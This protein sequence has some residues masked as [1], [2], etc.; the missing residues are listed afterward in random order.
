MDFPVWGIDVAYYQSL[1]QTS[2]RRLAEFQANGLAFVIAKASMRDGVDTACVGHSAN[3]RAVSGLALGHYHWVDPTGGIHPDTRFRQL[4]HLERMVNQNRPD[5]IAPDLEHWW[6]SWESYWQASQGKLPWGQVP[7]FS[8]SYLNEHAWLIQQE[9]ERRFAGLPII[10]YT[11]LWFVRQ[12][13]P[14]MLD[15][16]SQRPSW[17]AD[18]SAQPTGVRW[19]RDW[20]TFRLWKASLVAPRYVVNPVWSLWQ[21]ASS[22]VLPGFNSIW[23]RMDLNVFNGDLT[24]FWKML[25]DAGF[26]YPPVTPP[27]PQIYR[28]TAWALAVR[29][30]PNVLHLPVD[31][32]V[33]DDHVNVY[34]WLG[35]WVR[36][37]PDRWVNS[38]YLE[39][40]S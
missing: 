19:V 38:N 32:K 10:P 24:Q 13:A 2:P 16:L 33:R 21:F 36:I 17:I 6:A 34:E 40:V 28:V 37:G 18:Y 20:A 4:D 8:A 22:W 1:D 12:Y 9:L 23:H 27:L 15:W 3:T 39:R 7:R 5:F 31:W 35:H 25:G 26:S 14:A 11:G 29:R 30:T